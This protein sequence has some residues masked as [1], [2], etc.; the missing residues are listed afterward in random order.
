MQVHGLLYLIQKLH[1]GLLMM[2]IQRLCTSYFQDPARS[3]N[4]S[5][6]RML[7]LTVFIPHLVY[8]NEIWERNEAGKY[9]GVYFTGGATEILGFF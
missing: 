3:I 5:A 9:I 1:G 6:R 4:L 7:L 8:G 2:F